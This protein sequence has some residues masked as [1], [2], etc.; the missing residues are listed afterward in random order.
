MDREVY[1]RMSDLE[2]RHWWF[3]GRREILADLIRRLVRP[4]DGARIL[5][6]GCGSGGNLGMLSRFGQVDAFEYD[7][8]ARAIASERAVHEIFFGA[9]PSAVCTSAISM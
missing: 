6:A 5:E 7:E 3:V 1:K 8:A 9:L 2:M 4:K